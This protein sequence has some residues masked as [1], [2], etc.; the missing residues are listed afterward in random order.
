MTENK[1]KDLVPI[2]KEVVLLMLFIC[3]QDLASRILTCED[4]LKTLFTIALSSQKDEYQMLH[5]RQPR[6][7]VR[8]EKTFTYQGTPPSLCWAT[9]NPNIQLSSQEPLG[10]CCITKLFVSM[11]K[12]WHVWSMQSRTRSSLSLSMVI[13]VRVRMITKMSL[14]SL[15]SEAQATHIT[16]GSLFILAK[17]DNYFSEI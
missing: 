1:S 15:A 4:W 8:V 9:E 6:K 7:T 13:M 14:R 5:Q 12:L 16:F 11:L 2:V 10:L 3:H 17:N